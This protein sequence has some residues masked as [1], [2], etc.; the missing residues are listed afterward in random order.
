MK[1]TLVIFII[2]NSYLF[3]QKTVVQ[4]VVIENETKNPVPFASVF[5][6]ESKIG[7]VTDENGEFKIETY[8]AS[9]ILIIR[10]TEFKEK[11]VPVKLDVSQ[12]LVI[13]LDLNIQTSEEVVIFAPEEKPSTILYRKIERNRP[14]NNK[15]KLDAYEYESYNKVQIDLNNLGDDFENS[16]IVSALDLKNYIDTSNN[17]T[18]LPAILSESLSEYYVKREPRMRKEVI[19]ASRITGVDNLELDQFLGEMYQD[20]NVYDNFIGVFD[21]SLISPISNIAL[22][23]YTFFIE[24]STFIDNQWCYLLT[25]TPKRTGELTL[26]GKMWIH[27]TT[28]AVKSWEATVNKGVN[29]NY[30]NDLYLYQEFEQVKEGA[31]ML[32]LENLIIDLQILKSKKSFGFIGKKLV[33]RKNF[34]INQPHPNS[35]YR[36]QDNVTKED[37]YNNRS[38]EYWEEHRHVPLHQKDLEIEQMI[39]TLNQ[40]PLFKF[41]KGLSHM[42]VTGYYPISYI[43]IGNL[44]KVIGINKVEG[45]RNQLSLRTSNEFSRV[46]QIHGNV[47]YG[48]R[49]KEFKYGGGIRWNITPKKRGMLDLYYNYDVTQLGLGGDM[50]DV[51]EGLGSLIRTKPLTQLTFVEK[52]GLKFEKDVG[53][54]LIFT[55]S[56]EWREVTPLG[57]TQFR[58]PI[59]LVGFEKIENIRTFESSLKIRWAKQEEFISGAFD[60]ISA[61]SRFPIVSLEG[62]FGIPGVLDSDYEYQRVEMRIEH[63]PRLGILGTLYY[64]VYGGIYFGKA[65]YP[66]LKIHEGAQTYWAQSFAYN[67]MDYFEFISDKYVG[68]MFEH[69]FNGLILGHI[70]GMDVLRWR[71]VLSGRS[72]WGSISDKQREI[73]TLPD[74][75]KSFG[76]IPYVE[77]ALGIENIFNFI[78]IDVVWRMTHNV[79]G[80]SPVGVRGKLTF[81][82]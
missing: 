71:L 10:S 23:F 46:L 53:R 15:E 54:S 16:K 58:K 73:M 43:E 14:I 29:I 80:E 31:W 51:S 72:V 24:D 40:Q 35:F 28:F 30:V 11:R 55:V 78:R 7:T 59:G 33:S 63:R 61:G 70:P 4:G 12:E 25:F 9:E 44:M 65:A 26:E 81:R 32:K 47:A 18:S 49:D 56:G 3:A 41:F 1:W 52:A 27:D 79:Y 60:R 39:D 74:N 20:I 45:F 66:F 50:V 64:E 42:L 68:A 34:V 62:M 21:K 76:N 48:Y 57:E 2:A 67:K 8:Y 19:K 6:E 17:S 75:T 13:E 36:T 37:G 82:F 38:E 5:F 22:S 69:H 77:S